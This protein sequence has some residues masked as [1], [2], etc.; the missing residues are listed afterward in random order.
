MSDEARAAIT[1]IGD[2]P[3]GLSAALFLAK[4]GHDV[5]VFGADETV[6]HYAYLHNY[7]GIEGMSGTDFQ[8]LAREQVVAKGAK[9]VGEKVSTIEA[10]GDGFTVRSDGGETRSEYLILSEGNKTPLADNLGLDKADNRVVVDAN[11]RASVSRVYV[12]GRSVRPS[13]SQAI[14]SAGDGAAAALDILSD[15]AGKDVQDWDSPPKS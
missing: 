5:T 12:V 14:I 1:I 9:L 8:R 3:G 13:R 2:G 6:M 15:I 7:L 10:T 4:A 11:G